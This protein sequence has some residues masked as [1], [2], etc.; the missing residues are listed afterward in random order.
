MTLIG[1]LHASAE[2]EAGAVRHTNET[3]TAASLPMNEPFLSMPLTTFN[4]A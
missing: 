3:T 1:L 2:A 4:T